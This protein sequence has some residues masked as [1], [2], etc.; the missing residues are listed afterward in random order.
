MG[1]LYDED[2]GT[3]QSSLTCRVVALRIN[4]DFVMEFEAELRCKTTS[5]ALEMSTL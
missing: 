2:P 4:G 1:N 5:E 3:Q